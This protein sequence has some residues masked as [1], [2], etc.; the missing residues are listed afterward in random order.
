MFVGA[1]L[2]VDVLTLS[3]WSGVDHLTRRL[4]NGTIEVRLKRFGYLPLD[5]YP[6]IKL[7]VVQTVCIPACK[8]FL[9]QKPINFIQSM[10]HDNYGPGG[11]DFPS[12]HS[13]IRL[14]GWFFKNC[15]ACSLTTNSRN[16]RI[17][18]HNLSLLRLWCKK[19]SF[20]F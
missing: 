5:F 3:V 13:P 7:I 17:L 9:C 15:F 8:E 10:I 11:L 16:V 2:L 20:V 12:P 4:Q 14:V 18:C 1:L 19:I 6:I